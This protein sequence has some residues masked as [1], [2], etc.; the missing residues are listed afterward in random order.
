MD[1]PLDVSDSSCQVRGVGTVIQRA[2][3]TDGHVLQGTAYAAL[4]GTAGAA[5]RPWCHY[6]ARPGV[7]AGLHPAVRP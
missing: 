6:L 4:E 2:A 1:C 5:R 3:I 7:V